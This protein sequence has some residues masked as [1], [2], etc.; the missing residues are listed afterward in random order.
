LKGEIGTVVVREDLRALRGAHRYA[1]SHPWLSFSIDLSVAT[2][3]FWMLLGEA[4]SK[5]EHISGVPLDEPTRDLLHRIYFAKG[6]KATTAIE[7]NTL[8]EEEVF[9]R[10]EGED[11]GLP[12]SQEYLEREVDN[13]LDAYNEILQ[14]LRGGTRLPLGVSTLCKLNERILRNLEL[15]DGVVPGKVRTHEVRAGTYVGA[16]WR[17]CERLLAAM[18]E[19]LEGPAFVPPSPEMAL[20]YAFVKAVVAHVY[21]EWI[22]AFGDG[23]GRLGRLVEFL[24]LISS[25]APQAAAHV[26]TSHYNDTRTEYY[27]QLTQA[28]A[29]GGDLIPFLQY[30]ARGFVDGLLAQIARVQELQERLMW[31]AL[32]DQRFVGRTSQ[33][34]LRQKSLAI[35]LAELP[36]A[37]KKAELLTLTPE[38]AAAYSRKTM[39]TVSR[40]IN[41]LRSAGFVVTNASTV[42]ARVEMLDGFRSFR[43]ESDS[44]ST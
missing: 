22:H 21:I 29:S 7:G 15:E 30:A 6:V 8:S 1:I 23:N 10:I 16:P 27:R 9:R 42:R 31:R 19:W 36:E 18:C 37:V 2:P 24:I 41:A 43:F 12:K 14:D 38:L 40:D 28:S 17:E 44:D 3:G 11:L 39:K 20:P 33:A 13:M 35:A 32:V 26:L 25:G 4:R 5:C 34:A